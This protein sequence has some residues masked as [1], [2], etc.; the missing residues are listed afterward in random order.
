MAIEY[1]VNEETMRRAQSALDELSGV[2]EELRKE[3]I[4]QTLFTT[5]W[6]ISSA[7]NHINYI[8]D[9]LDIVGT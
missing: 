2:I 3:V 4:A 8:Q 7:V 1:S 6:P 9:C 5:P